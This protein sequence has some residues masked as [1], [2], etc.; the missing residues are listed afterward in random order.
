MPERNTNVLCLFDVDGTLAKSMNKATP[1]MMTMLS[2]LRAKVLTGV[3]GGSNLGKQQS[4]LGPS[5]QKDFD[6]FFA[7]NGLCAFK[8]GEMLASTSIKDYL[9]E[10]NIKVRSAGAPLAPRRALHAR[11]AGVGAAHAIEPPRVRRAARRVARRS[12]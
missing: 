12:S 6:F 8:D 10:Q 7:E 2:Q 9:G 11:T 4:Q 3:V 5:C 1:E